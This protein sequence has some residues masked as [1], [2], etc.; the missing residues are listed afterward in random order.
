MSQYVTVQELYAAPLGV[1]WKTVPDPGPLAR[2]STVTWLQ[3]YQELLEIIQ[4]AG[5][6]INT[7]CLQSLDAQQFQEQF[8]EGGRDCSIDQDGNVSLRPSHFPL[9]AVVS[10][11]WGYLSTSIN[12]NTVPVAQVL[13]DKNRALWP[14]GLP[15]WYDYKLA[16]Q[17][18]YQAGFPNANL[19]ASAQAGAT[20]LALSELSGIQ[21]GQPLTIYEGPNT[22]VIT[23]SAGW[24]VSSGPGSLTLAAGTQNA[25]TIS[26]PTPASSAVNPA[27]DIQVSGLPRAIR[28][29]CLL[30][31]KFVIQERGTGAL[32][33]G[34]AGGHVI[35]GM[36]KEAG[37]LPVSITDLL[38]PYMRQF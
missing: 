5:D 18:T 37:E 23:V 25:H 36:N 35:E 15:R 7:H 1:D 14:G 30:T 17:M 6:H 31:C 27:N 24:T 9:Q 26:V 29:A 2:G 34:Q 28:R 22:E 33:A 16:A 12:W 21:P 4:E 3:N 38:W 11:Q 10:M 20:T 8:V 13:I 19:T 32:V